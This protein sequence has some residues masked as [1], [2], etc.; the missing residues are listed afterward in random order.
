ML[1]RPRRPD[2]FRSGTKVTK[3]TKT[4][5]YFVIVVSFVI[6]VSALIPSAVAQPPGRDWPAATREAKPWTRWW[7]QGSAVDA[8]TLIT[9]LRTL[10]AGQSRPGGCATADG[11]SADTKIT[12][13][14]TITK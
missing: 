3:N 9:E 11:M 6:F 14:T 7:W 10:A 8:G 1:E 5:N 2:G 4:T 12:K 13:D